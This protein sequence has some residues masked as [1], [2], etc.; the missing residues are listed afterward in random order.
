MV[1]GVIGHRGQLALSRVVLEDKREPAT[2]TLQ[3]PWEEA[4]IVLEIP[5]NHGVV[6]AV[7]VQVSQL[8]S[9]LQI[10]TS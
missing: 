8:Y 3:R 9:R 7:H 6:T 4:R 1:A 10:A 2:A 5:R